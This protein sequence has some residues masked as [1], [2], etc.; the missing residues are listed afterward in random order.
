MEDHTAKLREILADNQVSA[1]DAPPTKEILSKMIQYLRNPF[2][3]NFFSLQTPNKLDKPN[4]ISADP[5]VQLLFQNLSLHKDVIQIIHLPMVDLEKDADI[6]E[7]FS[8]A[9]TFIAYVIPSAMP[10][11]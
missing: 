7:V 1:E 8:L 2:S 9:Y 5:S 6:R 11:H 3:G 4:K 10:K